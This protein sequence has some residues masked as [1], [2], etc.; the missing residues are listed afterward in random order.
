[1]APA[2]ATLPAAR[3]PACPNVAELDAALQD[4]GHAR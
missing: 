3:V 2:P 1:M 4:R